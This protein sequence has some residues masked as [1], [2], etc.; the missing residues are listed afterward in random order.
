MDKKGAG[1]IGY[2]PD[3]KPRGHTGHTLRASLLEGVR[4]RRESYMCPDSWV[5]E[6]DFVT[7]NEQILFKRLRVGSKSVVEDLTS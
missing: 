2:R 6:R 4:T 7:K 1:R 3:E 5:R